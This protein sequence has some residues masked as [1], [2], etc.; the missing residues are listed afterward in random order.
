MATEASEDH[1][2]YY[3][4]ELGY[5]RS[6]GLAFGKQY[7][8]VAGRLEYTGV[9]GSADPHVERMVESFA[10][11]TGR[12]QR[13]IDNQLPDIAA[14][15]LDV[16]YPQLLSPTPSMSIAAFQPDPEQ[17]RA[18]LGFEIPRDTMLF[19]AADDGLTC[20]FQTKYPVTIWPIEVGNA[21]LHSSAGFKFLDE[22]SDVASVLR[23]GLNC[24]GK[25][26]FAE[27]SPPKLRFFIQAPLAVSATLYELL[28]NSVVDVAVMEPEG[29]PIFL[30]KGCIKAVG[31]DRDEE[32][33]PYLPHAH[34]GY[35]L[36]QEYF[37][38]PEKFL[39][40]DLELDALS[41]AGRLANGRSVDLLFMVSE[42]PSGAVHVDRDTFRLGCTPIINLF[43]K[44]SEPVRVDQT[45]LEYFLEPDYRWARATEIHSILKVSGTSAFEDESRSIQPFFSFTHEDLERR[46]AA[47]WVARRRPTARPDLRGTDVMLSFHDLDFEPTQPATEIVFAHTLCTNRGIAEQ[48]V[49]STPLEI[50][51]D[52]PIRMITCLIK[53][54]R[55]LDPHRS[56]DMLWRLVS[57][58]SVNYLSLS[59]GEDS[60][61]ALREILRIYA[62]EHSAT[63]MKQVG[64]LTDLKTR[65]VVRRIGK[66]AWRGFCRGTEVTLTFDETQFV[67]GSAFLMSAV[68]CRFFGL[69]AATNSFTQLVVRSRQRDEIWKT[70]PPL[71]GETPV[72]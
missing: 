65:R 71:A 29:P 55:Q 3:L 39:F 53:P 62:G 21:G 22:R 72:L 14:S 25:R 27:F 24:S 26:V 31:F 4:A 2:R 19:A 41:P 20:R 61:A 23:I 59:E 47:F 1:L 11:L 67:G 36:I 60:L 56:G 30:K 48:L 46:Q 38:F 43:R 10:F 70:W 28:L 12:L 33:L 58:L 13:D 5:L 35:R 57:H 37:A 15:L 64:G 63:V 18:L 54:T 44:V 34:S 49:A 69:Y 17:S 40:F 50:E 8:R 7:P 9:G 52:A 42:R 32:V 6:A 51:V 68:L 16:L 66:D 45:Q